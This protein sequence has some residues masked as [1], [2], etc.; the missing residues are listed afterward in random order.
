MY[1]RSFQIDFLE[2][3]GFIESTHRNAIDAATLNNL[4]LLSFGPGRTT[5]SIN[6]EL[7]NDVWFEKLQ[8]IATSAAFMFVCPIATP[9]TLKEI[10]FVAKRNFCNTLF[11]MPEKK[12]KANFNI[13]GTD[14]V[15]SLICLVI[16][17][18]LSRNN[19]VTK[20]IFTMQIRDPTSRLWEWSRREL[21]KSKI[22]LP[23]YNESGRVFSLRMNEFGKFIE[24]V[25]WDYDEMEVALSQ[26][27]RIR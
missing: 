24:G 5:G 10:N 12:S 1:L 23:E 26:A 11:L 8:P 22:L 16:L 20:D 21:I 4:F 27:L 3:L 9:A 13:S 17:S 25:S 14:T 7:E 15:A 2:R 6:R 18:L 19:D